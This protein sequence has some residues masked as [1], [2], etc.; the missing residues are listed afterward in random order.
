MATSRR[1]RSLPPGCRLTPWASVARG[2]VDGRRPSAVTPQPIREASYRPRRQPTSSHT[3]WTDTRGPVNAIAIYEVLL[4]IRERVQG[5]EHPDTLTTRK[6]LAVVYREAGRVE[7]A[8]RLEPG[9]ES[10]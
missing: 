9:R 7:D 2:W 1:T 4:P 5:A 6:N 3:W 8:R 10:L